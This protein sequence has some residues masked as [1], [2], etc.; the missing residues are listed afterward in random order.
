MLNRIHY[1]PLAVLDPDRARDFYRDKL[2]LTVERDEGQGAD[3]IV[4][5]GLPWGE[6][7]LQLR[8]VSTLPAQTLPALVFL[9][10]DVDA[11]CRELTA[12]GTCIERWPD[13]ASDAGFRSAT[14]HDT[15]G[16]LIQIQT[17]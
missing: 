13:E 14:L 2:A 12:R 9:T 8:P 17:V 1:Q 7:L 15:E 10:D 16:N 5:L 4:Q 6:T 3:R 11:T